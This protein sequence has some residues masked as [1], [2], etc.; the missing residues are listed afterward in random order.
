MTVV[1]PPA[2]VDVA[3]VGS[4]LA[5]MAAALHVAMHGKR[6]AVVGEGLGASRMWSGAIDIG[7]DLHDAVPSLSFDPFQRGPPIR[8]SVRAIASHH[9]QHPYARFADDDPMAAVATLSSSW[10]ELSLVMRD[11]GHNH[12]L[13]TQAG[14]LKRSSAVLASQAFDVLDVEDGAVIAIAEWR[15]L[16]GFGAIPVVEMLRFQASFSTMMTK[17]NI[18]FVPVV[19]PRVGEVFDKPAD[20]GRCLERQGIDAHAAAL[21]DVV[22]A[23]GATHVLLPPMMTET[24][25]PDLS[26]WQRIVG[27]PVRELVAMPPA[28][29]GLRLQRAWR[30]VCGRVG[31][32]VRSGRIERIHIAGDAVGGVDLEGGAIIRAAMTILATGRFFSGGLVRDHQ[33]EEPLLKV[34]LYV[35]GIPVADQYI[36]S[37]TGDHVDDDHAIFRAGLLTNDRLQPMRSPGVVAHQ[38]VLAAGSVVGGYDLSRHGAAGGVAM[39]LGQRAARIAMEGQR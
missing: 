7:D 10:P 33:A 6:V 34:P 3:V 13:I 4:G 23:A 16:A 35:D 5:G 19:V 9:P 18:R 26:S 38:G 31:V 37:L 8:E 2:E 28:P 25:T 29:M 36:G 21:R 32:I 11:D 1:V 15:D 14:T 24:M 17:R 27:V 22:Q 12:M 30:D 39:Q 20:L